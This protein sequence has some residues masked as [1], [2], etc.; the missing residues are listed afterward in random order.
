MSLIGLLIT[1]AVVWALAYWGAGTSV[2]VAAFAVGLTVATLGTDIHWYVSIPIWA[3]ATAMVLLLGVPRIRRRY[4]T[5]PLLRQFRKVMPGMSRTEREAL[6]AGTTWWDA[7]LFSGNPHWGRLL[8]LPR[9]HLSTQEQAFLDGPTEQ[10]C[11]M[12][13]DW[14]ITHRDQDLSP[15]AWDFIRAEGFFGLII[16]RHYGGKAFSAQAHSEVVMKLASRS[17]AAAVTV[18]VPN[19]LGPGKLLMSYGTREQC[20]YYLPRLARGE[21]IPCFALTGPDAGSDAGAIPDHG[22]VCHGEWQGSQVLGVRLNWDKRYITL[23]PVCTLLGLAFR[24][25][26]P[27]GL[28]GEQQDLGITLA[29]VPRDTPGVEIGERHVP[30]NIPFQNGPNRGHDVFVPLSQLIG[31]REGIGRG[32]R[33]LV[34]CLAE[35]RGISLP[36]LSVGAGKLAS[37]YTGAY[38][39]IRRQFNI[40]IGR[41]E[42]IEKPLARIAGLTYQ[43]DAARN[44]TLGGL[45]IG[46][47]PSVVSAIIK[48][49]LTEKYRQCIN[50]AM[51]IQGGSGICLG[52]NNLIGRVYQAIPIAITVEGANILTRSMIIFGQG[53]IRA[54]PWVLKEFMA[55]QNPDRRQGL[56]DFDHALFGHLG[57]LLGNLARSLF[58][59]L[60]RGHLSFAP[61]KGPVRRYYQQLGW[62]SAAFAL[63][64]DVA[65]MTLG[66]SLKRKERLSARLGDILSEL[67]LSSAVLKR[68]ED[69]GR[70]DDDLPLVRWCMEQSLY[71][72]QEAFRLL[73]RNLPWRP[74]GWLLRLIV[75]PSGHPFT[76]PRDGLDHAVTRI[77]LR[78]GAARDRLTRGIFI[79]DDPAFREGQIEQ[80]F[81]HAAKVAPTEKTLRE[82]RR[83]GLIHGSNL[84]EQG[85]QALAQGLIDAQEMEALQEMQRLRSKVV[86]VD[87][88][89]DW[90]NQ[91]VLNRAIPDRPSHPE[92]RTANIHPIKE[93]RRDHANAK[94]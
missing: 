15:A 34:E 16:P 43:M 50:D 47:K 90:G 91:H 80:A 24:L 79:S 5:A 40:S 13:D 19:S 88:F 29:L 73:F 9:P 71:Q 78:P 59:G 82:A 51:D 1:I 23:G 36:S 93:A 3:L 14:Q 86:A 41:F 18:M 61:T 28:L 76:E 64:A 35:G 26:D 87:A 55:A 85:E 2:W 70:L 53:A 48:Y 46:E 20:D 45:D 42:G 49:H 11:R 17:V 68:F 75:F 62:M 21:E 65:M 38:A 72:M 94:R 10:L 56:A 74:L 66:G 7:E 6:E 25:Y 27:D 77:L 8:R 44:L 22:V 39:A 57:F 52:P 33:M 60:T 81:R 32:W 37:R 12:L 54:H 92:N 4:V 58:L 30:L 84:I 67:Y 83:S 89:S 63:C 69:E 31:G